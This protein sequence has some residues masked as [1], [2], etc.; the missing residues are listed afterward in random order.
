MPREHVH[1]PST[2]NIVLEAEIGVLNPNSDK[3]KFALVCTHPYSMMGGHMSNN[4]PSALFKHFYGN[5]SDLPQQLR[6]SISVVV[7]FNFR[8]VGES[9]GSSTV[10]A[11]D[12]R[13]D[14][15]A[16]CKYI[17]EK[18]KVDKIIILGYSCGSAIMSGI[19]DEIEQVDSFAAISYPKGWWASWIFGG[20]Y[21]HIGKK[22]KF[23]ILGTQDQ[24]A[25][26]SSFTKWYDTLAE[27]K[28]LQ[29]IQDADH[30]WF[31]TEDVIIKHIQ[32]WLLK[33]I[34]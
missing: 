22:P 20:H 23:F 12:E 21:S 6:D 33:R 24:F 18:Y 19:A 10:T 7:K 28:E 9:T 30:F 3:T 14:G 4:V 34:Q 31:G 16:V 32:P 11:W 8:G 5:N 1:I 29:I 2:G 27:P 26:V 17:V 13:E 15:K 25:S